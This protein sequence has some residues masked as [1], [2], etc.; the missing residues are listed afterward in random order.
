[1]EPL[2][3]D[4]PFMF[5]LVDENDAGDAEKPILPTT[6]ASGIESLPMTNP[7]WRFVDP[8]PELFALVCEATLTPL[9]KAWFMPMFE[10]PPPGIEETLGKFPSMFILLYWERELTREGYPG[11]DGAL[12]PCPPKRL[13]FARSRVAG[14]TVGFPPTWVGGPEGT[15]TQ[16]AST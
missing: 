2:G 10:F 9:L 6:P 15:I 13:E 1:M 14:E 5:R 16:C 8:I 11:W 7:L 12:P 4:D 3:P